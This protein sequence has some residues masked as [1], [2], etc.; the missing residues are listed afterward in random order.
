[1][2]KTEESGGDLN[3]AMLEYRNSPIAGTNLTPAELLM[4]RTLRTKL[5]VLKRI[6]K[7]K[8]PVNA[9]REFKEIQE[10]SKKYYDRTAQEAERFTR[11]ENVFIQN[12][13]TRVW[14]EAEVIEEKETPRSYVVRN[15]E[16]KEYRRNSSAI[17]K[18]RRDK[19]KDDVVET[20]SKSEVMVSIDAEVDSKMETNVNK[21]DSKNNE[22]VVTRSGRAIRKP[23]P[24]NAH[25]EFKE[26][27]EKSKKYYDRTAQEAE[28][29]T[30]GENVFIQNPNTR[31]WEEAEVIE[32]KETPRSYVVKN[33]EGKEYRRNSSAI[34]KDRRDKK[35]DDVV[36]TESK[37]RRRRSPSIERCDD[38]DR[39]YGG[40]EADEIVFMSDRITYII[41][42]NILLSMGDF[43]KMS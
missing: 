7:P 27:Q 29:F 22:S 30:R 13:N 11:G 17:R 18:D 25:R 32:E 16:G 24:V 8:I 10:K 1:M 2:K 41:L 3:Y 9:H 4:N 23:I 21:V 36:E 6:L 33:K 20:E 19:K 42:Y 43:P 14:E 40:T 15:K 37:I 28:R 5:P 35:K 12:P 34:R 26:I 31:V 39:D 38:Q